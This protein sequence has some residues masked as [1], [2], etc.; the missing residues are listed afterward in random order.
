MLNVQQEKA[1]QLAVQAYL[2]GDPMFGLFGAGG[3]GK[4]YCVQSIIEELKKHSKH[5]T[6]VLYLAPT[7][8]ALGTLKES[9]GCDQ[10]DAK[11]LHSILEKKPTYDDKGKRAFSGVREKNP[12]LNYSFVVVD[13][14]SMINKDITDEFKTAMIEA[15]EKKKI[16]I[17]GMGEEHQHL[18][19]KEKSCS[20]IDLL[21]QYQVYTL[22]IVMRQNGE[23]PIT[24]VIS[25]ARE[26]VIKKKN[27]Y[28]PR[29]DFETTTTKIDGE[30][31]GLWVIED[32]RKGM[33]QVANAYRK[34]YET[35]NWSLVKCVCWKNV[36]VDVMNT[37]IRNIL[38]AEESFT[39]YIPGDLVGCKEP[40][41]EWVTD[42]QGRRKRVTVLFSGDELIVT[43]AEKHY[44]NYNY[45]VFKC[46]EAG[47]M[48]YVETK[49]VEYGYWKIE[50]VLKDEINN[51]EAKVFNLELIALDCKEKYKEANEQMRKIALAVDACQKIRIAR[52]NEGIK[53]KETDMSS[54]PESKKKFVKSVAYEFGKYWSVYYIHN[55][56][57]NQ[58]RHN[59]A[60]TSHMVQG[61]TFDNIMMDCDEVNSNKFDKDLARRVFYVGLS[62][63]KK[64]IGLIRFPMTHKE[65]DECL[66]QKADTWTIEMR[67][68]Q[69]PVILEEKPLTTIEQIEASQQPDPM[70]VIDSVEGDMLKVLRSAQTDNIEDNAQW[71][72]RLV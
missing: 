16:F 12:F 43:A 55:E 64:R 33:A 34:M 1:K 13:E 28:D 11:T 21:R 42:E 50:G 26:A 59:Y 31:V 49:S 44:W 45:V 25:G 29:W 66:P 22:T 53:Y 65:I 61:H 41:V 60:T 17:I 56:R 72:K 7:N 2:K 3:T 57:F 71:W 5:G 35:Q 27:A 70:K 24:P 46:T 40:I 58:A 18:P 4:T 19:V 10:K 32:M 68:A 54:V 48:D 63:A 6:S 23:N 37:A 20:F 47:T 9:T 62:R 8:S 39:D 69:Q 30:L 36:T 14:V 15:L 38:F 52:R 67:Q 51:P